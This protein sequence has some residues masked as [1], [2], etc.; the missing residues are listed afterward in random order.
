MPFSHRARQATRYMR[1]NRTATRWRRRRKAQ[2][3]RTKFS[4][5]EM[6]TKIAYRNV[7]LSLF[8]LLS[9]RDKFNSCRCSTSSSS[10]WYYLFRSSFPRHVSQLISRT[11][12][13]ETTFLLIERYWISF[14]YEYCCMEDF[15]RLHK[16]HDTLNRSITTLNEPPCRASMCN[17]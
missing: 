15:A 1:S 8:L 13:T 4:I 3:R 10:S 7:N 11:V 5:R 16:Q 9:R 14:N 2:T 17:E 6:L 12:V